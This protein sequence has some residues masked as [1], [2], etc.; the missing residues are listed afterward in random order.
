M[1]ALKTAVVGA[2]AV[3]AGC[4][5]S[6]IPFIEQGESTQTIS[7]TRGTVRIDT[8]V[9]ISKAFSG[10]TCNIADEANFATGEACRTITCQED[11]KTVFGP[12]KECAGFDQEGIYGVLPFN[13][14]ALESMEYALDAKKFRGREVAVQ[15][16]YVSLDLQSSLAR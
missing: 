1:G 9:K 14:E 11:K 16:P 4:W 10:R 5:A 15:S 6:Q 13:E 2:F 12:K 7:V 3:G 8:P